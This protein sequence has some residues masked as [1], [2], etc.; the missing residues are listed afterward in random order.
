[1]NN[2]V[3]ACCSDFAAQY[4]Q[5]AHPAFKALERFV[6]GSDYGG[7][8]WTTREQADRAGALLGLDRGAHLLE[9]GSGSGWPGIYL[10]ARTGCGLSLLDL[11]F[12]ALR[13]A[14]QR[15]A[16]EGIEP[17][18]NA[19]C[20][21]GA[22]LPFEAEV[23]DVLSHSDVLCC[24]P[25]KRAML[26]EC[27]RV[28]RGGARML[29]WVIAPPPGLRGPGLAAA[30]EAGPPFVELPED[31]SAL[32]RKTG[33]RILQVESVSEAYAETLERMLDGLELNAAAL[34]EVMGPGELPETVARRRA[35]LSAVRRG[36][37][38][39]DM[40]LTEAAV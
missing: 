29:F 32:L 18:V 16:Q 5:N 27:R 26:R 31:Y 10:A 7:T 6:L 20:A 25:E 21:S 17:T 30:I 23:F 37:L 15:A 3:T 38:V 19:V 8:S 13:L 36:L 9:L 39:R 14:R 33:W 40:Y 22:Q 34:R 4:D 1:M 35:Q 12:N 2:P 24:L 28:A 11:P